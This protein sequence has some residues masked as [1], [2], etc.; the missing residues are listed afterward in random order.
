MYTLPV[1]FPPA[2][3]GPSYVG[4]ASITEGVAVTASSYTLAIMDPF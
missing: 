4:C 1:A 3:N 2:S